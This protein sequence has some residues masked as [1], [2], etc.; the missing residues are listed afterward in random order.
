MWAHYC[1]DHKGIVVG[2]DADHSAFHDDGPSVR[3]VVYVSQCPQVIFSRM[4]GLD[5][6]FTKNSEWSYEEE[7]RHTKILTQEG[8]PGLPVHLFP[9]PRECVREIILARMPQAT[10]LS[11]ACGEIPAS[12]DCDHEG[13]P[14]L[15]GYAMAASPRPNDI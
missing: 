2:F 11:G 12:V 7:V 13:C 6:W 9:L 1:E 4:T 15:N 10:L 14:T 8:L 5:S 3:P